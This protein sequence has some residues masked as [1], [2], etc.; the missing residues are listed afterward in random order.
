MIIAIIDLGTNTFNLLIVE[1]S[2]DN[3]HKPLFKTKISVKL[4]EGGINRNFIAPK[5]FERG[6]KAMKKHAQSIKKF[7]ASKIVAFATS[8]IRSAS[9]GGLFIETTKKEVG[10]DIKILSGNQEA[11]Y[12]YYGVCQ[13]LSLEVDNA[14]L[15]MDIG[16]G[17]MNL[18]LPTSKVLFGNKAWI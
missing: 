6:I 8:A 18:S 14:S 17:A 2:D 9:N 1:V 11:E 12:I 7:K 13:A 3:S 5:A 4:G 15:I 10:I 16:E